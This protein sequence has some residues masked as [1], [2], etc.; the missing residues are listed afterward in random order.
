M[1]MKYNVD[2]SYLPKDLQIGKKNGI[3]FLI[4]TNVA[5][6]KI[7]SNLRQLS[8]VI[9]TSHLKNEYLGLA[10]RQE[11]KWKIHGNNAPYEDQ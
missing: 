1:V 2:S 6:N 3:W 8:M 5:G 9:F 10:I 4:Q 11:L 7:R